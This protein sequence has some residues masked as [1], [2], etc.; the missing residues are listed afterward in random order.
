MEAEKTEIINKNEPQKQP[1][2][3]KGALRQVI[4]FVLL[5]ALILL[6]RHYIAAPTVVQGNSMQP[7]L[8]PWDFLI[9]NRWAGH[10]GD[11]TRGDIVILDPPTDQRVFI[12]RI[13][14]VGG[15][16]LQLIDGKV[17]VNGEMLD[18]PYIDANYTEPYSL[19][20][21][22]E[23]PEGNVFVM[24]DNRHPG[25]STDSRQIGLIPN[26]NILGKIIFRYFPFN[27]DFGPIRGNE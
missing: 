4:E 1:K 2:K 5:V 13:I 16:T 12:K 9:A 3:K 22:I 18:E 26:E 23:I 17:Y 20:F 11:F 14:A 19:I 7:T 24:G 21:P 27:K 8:H 6:F 15:D 10:T 25:G